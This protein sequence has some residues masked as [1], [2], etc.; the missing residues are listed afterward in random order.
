VLSQGLP[1]ILNAPLGASFS[2][3]ANRG[4]ARNDDARQCHVH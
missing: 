2:L 1:F 3:P 4:N